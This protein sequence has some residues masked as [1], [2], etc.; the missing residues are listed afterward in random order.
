MAK[1][2]YTP[3]KNK[4]KQSKL[5]WREHCGAVFEVGDTKNHGLYGSWSKEM[6]LRCAW[7]S[8]KWVQ[9]PHAQQ[10]TP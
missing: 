7:E 4:R 6:A 5:D 2:E 10:P 9:Q 3:G 8:V 1:N